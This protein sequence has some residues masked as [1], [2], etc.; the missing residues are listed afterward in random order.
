VRCGLQK[1]QG[2]KI[3]FEISPLAVKIEHPFALTVR[4]FHHSG[5]GRVAGFGL[6]A[7][8]RSYY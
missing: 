4:G 5:P 1:S 7:R 6:S 2:V 8:H 3:G